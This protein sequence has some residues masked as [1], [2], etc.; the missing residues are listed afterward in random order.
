MYFLFVVTHSASAQTSLIPFGSSWRYLDNGTNQ[1]TAWSAPSFSDGAWKTGT[2][3]FGYGISDARTS[4]SYGS[5]AKSKFI[6]T[7][8]RKAFSLTDPGAFTSFTLKMKRDDGVVIYLNGKEVHRNNMPTGSILYS[9]LAADGASDNGTNILTV[10]LPVSGFVAGTNVLAVEVHQ[11]KISTS[12][13][14]FDLELTGQASTLAAP[15][16]NTPPA[17]ASVTRL[18]PLTE[19]TTATFLTYRT[20]FS[21]AVTGVDAA[22]FALTS[23]GTALGQVSAVRAVSSST[24]E[25]TVSNATGQG[26]LRLDVKATGTNIQDVNSAGLSAGYTVGQSYTLAS[27]TETTTVQQ[28]PITGLFSFGSTWKYLDNG[29]NPGTTW[30]TLAF[31]DGSWKSGNGKFGYGITDAAT[32]VGFGPDGSNKYITTY[33]RK[34]FS[35][36][37]PALYGTITA[38]LRLDDAAVVYLNGKEVFRHNMPTGTITNTTIATLSAS[39]DGTKTQTLT[40]PAS[41]FVTGTNVIAVEVHQSKVNTSDMAFDLELTSTHY[42]PKVLYYEG[43]ESG[44]GFSSLHLQTSTTYGFGVASAPC[45]N[46]AKVGRWELRAGDAPV[47]DGTRAEV[48]F[49]ETLAQQETWHS[50][51][52][53]FPA[54]DYKLDSDDEAIN[55]WHQGSGFGSPMISLR[56][57][58]GRFIIRR[59][60]PDGNTLLAHDLG[61]IPYD[62]WAEVVVHIKQHLTAGIVQVWINGVQKLNL[63]GVPTMFNGPYGQWKLGI[64]KSTW[65][66]GNSTQSIKRVWYVD[67]VKLGN[68]AS[69]YE[70]MKPIGNNLS[71][72]LVQATSTQSLSLENP[73]VRQPLLYPNPAKRGSVLTLNTTLTEPTEMVVKDVTGRVMLTGKFSGTANIETKQL[74][75]GMYFI[76]TYGKDP[77]RNLRF[78]VTE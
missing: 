75:S 24:Y 65:N 22:D 49:P 51:A 53:Y 6:T 73:S 41:A 9:T 17:V 45:F 31:N 60:T 66:S 30:S 56:T 16:P 23:S 52:G 25:V 74:P 18:N 32:L 69:T 3:K 72:S 29:T 12:D 58:N 61:A 15:A 35:I 40:I 76:S 4:V 48:S 27:S 36:A 46:G 42:E 1:G 21:E 44:T 68:A 67:E 38:N 77:I 2:G 50:F 57:E 47:A 37:D 39:D 63:Q 8:F 11:Q 55:Q 7:Y 54:A 43:F 70:T 28:A 19:S 20:V 62:Q 59:R 78:I 71:A 26:T 33:F 10:S 64:Y 5:N 14:A 34:T 13:M